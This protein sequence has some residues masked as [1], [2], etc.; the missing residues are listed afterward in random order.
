MWGQDDRVEVRFRS[1]KEDQIAGRN[2]DDACSRGSIF[3]VAVWGRGSQVD[4][5]TVFFS[6]L[7]DILCACEQQQGTIPSIFAVCNVDYIVDISSSDGT[8]REHFRF[9]EHRFQKLLE[10]SRRL[11]AFSKSLKDFFLEELLWIQG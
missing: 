9:L 1:S 2:D 6:F 8:V 11:L 5:R 4:D 7:R 10:I 3:P